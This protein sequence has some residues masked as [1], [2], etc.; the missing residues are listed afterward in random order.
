MLG[1]LGLRFIIRYDPTR[2]HSKNK[3]SGVPDPDMYSK[4][5]DLSNL[6]P[7]ILI[8]KSRNQDPDLNFVNILNFNFINNYN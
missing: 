4:I 3:I 5:S 2:T 1:L 8:F 6:N 7:N